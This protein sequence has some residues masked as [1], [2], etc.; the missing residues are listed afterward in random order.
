MIVPI[1]KV[2]SYKN[3]HVTQR[4]EKDFPNNTLSAEEAFDEM[5]K[6]LWLSQKLNADKK[7]NPTN[8]NLAFSCVMHH[9]MSNIDDMWHTF[10]LFT[11]DYM[12]FCHL[13]FGKFIHHKPFTEDEAIPT[14]EHF[15]SELTRY[16][17]YVNEHLGEATLKKWFSE[18]V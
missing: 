5:L 2:L 3:N 7:Y 15:A 9:E 13:Y 16:L 17:Y 12:D 8:K 1:E 18:L 6:Y 10:L 14:E 11:K 4:Y